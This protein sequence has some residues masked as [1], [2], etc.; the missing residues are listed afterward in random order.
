LIAGDD[1]TSNNYPASKPVSPKQS[2]FKF[3]GASHLDKVAHLSKLF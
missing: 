3:K 1:T 2:L